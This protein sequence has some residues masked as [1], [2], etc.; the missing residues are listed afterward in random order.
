MIDDTTLSERMLAAVNGELG[1]NAT[2]DEQGD[3]RF[4]SGRG[5]TVWLPVDSSDPEYVHMLTGFGL[6]RFAERIGSPLDV[7]LPE[8]RLELLAAANRLGHRLKGAK[9]A[10]LPEKDTVI[11]SLEMI[12]AGKS[13]MPGVELVASILPRMLSMLSTAIRD[14]HEEVVLIGH[15]T[16][17]LSDL[18]SWEE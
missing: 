18:A 9:I 16:A 6:S 12:A 1:W 3:L 14:F 5:Y 17:E 13:R 10:I 8:V 11:F 15:S 2:V 7:S 4:D